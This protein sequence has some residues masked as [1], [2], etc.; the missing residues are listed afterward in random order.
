[1]F[2]GM[3]YRRGFQGIRKR[4]SAAETR[5]TIGQG[6]IDCRQ[7]AANSSQIFGKFSD[8]LTQNFKSNA[9]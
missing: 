6:L 8:R 3:L 9:P 2:P 5:R 7:F 1:M 4:R